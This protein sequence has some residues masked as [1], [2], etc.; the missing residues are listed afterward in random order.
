[1]HGQCEDIVRACF[2]HREITLLVTEI[3]HRAQQVHRNRIVS[4]A[5]NICSLQSV[6]D[7]HIIF[8]AGAELRPDGGVARQNGGQGHEAFQFFH[9]CGGNNLTLFH[10]FREKFHLFDEDGCLDRIQTG[11]Q[12]EAHVVVLI[13]CASAVDQHGVHLL[14]EFFVVREDRA[15]IAV[16]AQ[17]FCR[18][19]AGAADIPEGRGFLPAGADRAEALAGIFDYFHAVFFRNGIDLFVIRRLTEQV[20][21]HDGFRSQFAFLDDFFNG[22]FQ[23]HR[24]H[25]IS[26]FINIGEDRSCPN[27]R[28]GF[29]RGKEGEGRGEDRIARADL[30]CHQ[31][32]QKG[33]R[34]AGT[35]K[36]IFGSGI[37]RQLFFQFCDFRTENVMTA[38]QNTFDACEYIFFDQRILC[39][40]VNERNHISSPVFRFFVV[41]KIFFY[42]TS[43]I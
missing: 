26:F 22:F 29:G 38:V 32:H 3:R 42:I 8:V 33:V 19:E 17:R 25:V 6:L 16:A 31:S 1:M 18:E 43:I 23:F 14:I 12:T 37:I 10:F 21:R 24:I 27:K 41:F 34:A 2:G 11:I 39:F 30:K 15:A 35:G 36:C 4:G 28:N 40:Q 9:V 7:L 13:F 5:R 20:H